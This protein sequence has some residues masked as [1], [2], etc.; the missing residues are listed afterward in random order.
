M[1]EVN[2]NDGVEVTLTTLGAEI[3]NDRPFGKLKL[4]FLGEVGTAGPG[5]TMGMQLWELMQIFG[6]HLH[7]GGGAVFENNTIRILGR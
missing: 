1:P 2:L 6:P 5:Q 3:Y 7:I 4:A